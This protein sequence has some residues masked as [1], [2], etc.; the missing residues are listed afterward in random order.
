MDSVIAGRAV[1]AN[2]GLQF[3]DSADVAIASALREP[4]FGSLQFGT[5]FGGPDT[6]FMH[7]GGL[8]GSLEGTPHGS[9]HMAV[10]GWMQQFCLAQILGHLR[11]DI[12][13]KA[14]RDAT[15]NHLRDTTEA[16]KP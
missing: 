14:R 15:Q 5:G 4:E 16:E 2:A 11:Q 6:G 7:G 3:A 1:E 10:G 8:I 9:M 13:Q 12:K